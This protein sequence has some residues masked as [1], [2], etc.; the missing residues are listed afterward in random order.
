MVVHL[1]F[2]YCFCQ[3]DKCSVVLN[4][5]RSRRVSCLKPSSRDDIVI[6]AS[7]IL[8]EAKLRAATL[9]AKEAADK[10]RMEDQAHRGRINSEAKADLLALEKAGLTDEQAKEV[11][12]AIIMKQV[13]HVSISY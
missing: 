1:C 4:D 10:R 8:L 13:R 9:A 7:V 2:N 11:V 5:A 6:E 3:L 12:K